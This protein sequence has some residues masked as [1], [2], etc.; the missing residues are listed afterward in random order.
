MPSSLVIPVSLLI[1]AVLNL[2]MTYSLTPHLLLK[3]ILLWSLGL[4]L[5][6]IGRQFDL[7]L[8]SRRQGRYLLLLCLVLLCLPLLIGRNVRGSNRWLHLGPVQIQPSEI[9]RPII[10]ISQSTGQILAPILS[11]I[12]ILTYPD[13]GSAVS[14]L[15]LFFPFLILHPKLLKLTLALGL[16]FLVTTPITFHFL[17]DYQKNRLLSFVNPSQNS[18]TTGYHQIQSTIAIGSGGLFGQGLRQGSQSQLKFLPEKHTDFVFAAIAEE[19]GLL[20]VLLVLFTYLGLLGHLLL[21]S[22]RFLQSNPP[23]FV[24]ILGTCVNIWFQAFVN[25]GMNLGLLPIVGITLPFLSVGGSSLISL[26][27]SLGIISNSQADNTLAI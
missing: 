2:T 10:L 4:I 20:A 8:V 11:S 13:L 3:Q 1:F 9:T 23:Y 16:V 22:F 26:L 5:F 14:T 19:L 21:H 15:S 18:Q 7:R 27:F 6:L 25:I 17:R 12:I 24:F